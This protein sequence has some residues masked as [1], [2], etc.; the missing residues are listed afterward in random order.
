MKKTTSALFSFFIM[1]LVG[2]CLLLL[3]TYSSYNVER[4]PQ[5]PLQTIE[6]GDGVGG[7]GDRDRDRDRDSGLKAG[8]PYKILAVGD[9][10]TAGY[11]LSLSESYP[12]ILAERLVSAGKNVNV[13]N[14]G[15]SGETTA[16]LLERIEFIA[17]QKP[18]MVL[19]TIGGNDA[20]RNI[21]IAYTKENLIKIV[22]VLKKEVP[23]DAIY[24][25]QIRTP[26]NLGLGYS[27]QFQKMYEEVAD[28]EHI[29][30]LPFVEKEVFLDETKMLSDGIHP[31]KAGY[32]YIVDTF[33]FKEISTHFE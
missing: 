5:S 22:S 30:I 17:S 8:L 20:F 9:S 12:S 18:D 32:E 31:N 28:T 26:L 25:L 11:G 10:L 16:G 1:C 13:I 29:K 21:P 15:V 4:L 6:G 27:G 3:Y 33:L 23:E 24:L 7:V 2:G 14:A 19:I